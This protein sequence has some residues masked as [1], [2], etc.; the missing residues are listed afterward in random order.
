MLGRDGLDSK[1]F[2]SF[3]RRVQDQRYLIQE[4]LQATGNKHELPL[5]RKKSWTVQATVAIHV[6]LLMVLGTVL[7]TIV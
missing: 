7:F 1:S 5:K 2:R 4:T 3:Q 6:V